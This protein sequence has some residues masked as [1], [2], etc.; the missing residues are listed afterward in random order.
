[1]K[2]IGIIIAAI[3]VLV[4]LTI[5]A[6]TV[7]AKAEPKPLKGMNE[8][9]EAVTELQQQV[10]SLEEQVGSISDGV[11]VIVA[12]PN[13][14]V[15]IINETERLWLLIGMV[16]NVHPG[17]ACVTGRFYINSS[18]KGWWY[19]QPNRMINNRGG[20]FNFFYQ[21]SLPAGTHTVRFDYSV[22]CISGPP[23]IPVITIEEDA[24]I[25]IGLN[26]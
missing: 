7:F 15:T 3:V 18:F 1:M 4:G 17:N 5:G 12:S 13:T 20:T 22:A 11:E 21:V 16:N 23:P 6:S 14:D 10:Q 2:R 24:F 26:E 19:E 25:L 9:I 8:V